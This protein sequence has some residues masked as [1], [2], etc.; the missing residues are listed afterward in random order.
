[1][2]KNPGSKRSASVLCK[3]DCEFLVLDAETYSN[4]VRKNA[5]KKNEFLL[6]C[7]SFISSVSST[8]I[9]NK[10]VYSFM[11]TQQYTLPL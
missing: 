6:K 4:F 11:V 5:E 10:I 8:Q 9:K 2:L 3:T 1:M 7:F